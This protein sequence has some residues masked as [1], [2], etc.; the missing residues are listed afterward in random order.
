MKKFIILLFLSSSI[1]AATL[2]PEGVPEKQYIAFDA[3]FKACISEG[4]NY[5]KWLYDNHATKRTQPE[6][7]AVVAGYTTGCYVER[8]KS[9]CFIS[10]AGLN[11]KGQIAAPK[12]PVD[13]CKKNGSHLFKLFVN[14]N[15]NKNKKKEVKP[16]ASKAT[17]PKPPVL[18]PIEIVTPNTVDV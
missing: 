9:F 4:T 6:Y 8:T 12:D 10:N 7:E 18:K 5:A 15:I 14:E 2:P 16:P 3:T 17:E 13:S 1:F 11:D